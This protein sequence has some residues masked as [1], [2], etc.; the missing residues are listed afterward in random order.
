MTPDGLGL[1]RQ[2]G[3]VSRWRVRM[4]WGGITGCWR[5]RPRCS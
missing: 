2:A 3:S 1:Q 5:V 4:G